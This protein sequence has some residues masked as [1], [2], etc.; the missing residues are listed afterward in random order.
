MTVKSV[1]IIIVIF[2]HKIY[3]QIIIVTMDNTIVSKIKSVKIVGYLI[4]TV[5]NAIL[6]RIYKIINV[7]A[8]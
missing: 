2:K 4:N 6:I 7:L 1:H 5:I 3:A 8:V